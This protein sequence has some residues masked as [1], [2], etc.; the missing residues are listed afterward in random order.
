MDE[1]EK[2]KIFTNAMFDQDS[3]LNR[4]LSSA[5]SFKRAGSALASQKSNR[6]PYHDGRGLHDQNQLNKL[7]ANR[8]TAYSD[9]KQMP[10]SRWFQ[11]QNIAGGTPFNAAGLAK[12]SLVSNQRQLGERILGNG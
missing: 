12:Q 6:I 10:D 3:Q 7:E 1:N 4:K 9:N 2:R 11:D 8:Q 5:S